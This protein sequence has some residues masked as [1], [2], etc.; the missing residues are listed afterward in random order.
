MAGGSLV[1]VSSAF[2][3][4]F[5]FLGIPSHVGAGRRL[6]TTDVGVLHVE[7]NS[8]SHFSS[9]HFESHT[10]PSLKGA[11]CPKG[12]PNLD[13][14]TTLFHSARVEIFGG[15]DKEFDPAKPPSPFV[16]KFYV[17][18]FGASMY[19][20]DESDPN[21]TTVFARIYKCGNNQIRNMEKK[22]WTTRGSGTYTGS[23]S[24][25]EALG[26]HTAAPSENSQHHERHANEE[27]NACIFTAIRDPISHFL[28]GYNEVEYRILND[29]ELTEKPPLAPYNN[30]PY[31]ESDRR[32]KE[33]FSRFVTDVIEEDPSFVDHWVYL[34][35]MPMGRILP[36]LHRFNR[37]LTGY[38]PSLDNLT[39]EWPAFMARTCPHFPPIEELPKM[40]AAGQHESSEDPLGVYRAAKEVWKDRGPVARAMCVLH[41]FDYACW[42]DLPG[43]IPQLCQEVFASKSFSDGINRKRT[44][45]Y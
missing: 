2:T 12:V 42:D 35:F 45:H 31:V 17:G 39:E 33:R 15:D 41:A 34:H 9:R 23:V 21:L 36:F 16:T 22:L 11:L 40:E 8:S 4:L 38:L 1:L 43:G 29:V 6:E 14:A 25:L 26:L 32:R 28:S 18:D 3:A 37:S 7:S 24:L 10:W 19:T 13:L 27:H 20:D 30:V 5:L 44:H